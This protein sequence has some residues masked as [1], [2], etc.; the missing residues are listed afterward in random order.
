[1]KKIEFKGKVD[2]KR[3]KEF[4]GI[5]REFF[6]GDGIYRVK[7]GCRGEVDGVEKVSENNCV[8]VREVEDIK[9]EIISGKLKVSM[10]GWGMEKVMEFVNSEFVDFYEGVEEV[11]EES[12]DEEECYEYVFVGGESS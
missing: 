1:M 5:E 10:I 11:Y 7:I 9:K 4:Y 2:V 8:V 6:V 12:W 3:M